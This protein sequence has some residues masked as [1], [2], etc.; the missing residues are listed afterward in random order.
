MSGGEKVISIEPLTRVEGEGHLRLVMENGKIKEVSL[1]ID[2]TPRL[3]EAFLVGRK[4]DEVHEIASRICGICYVAHQITA[5]RAVEK[6]IGVSVTEEIKKLR[7][8]L[9]FAGWIQSHSLHLAFLALPDY[10]GH[11]SVFSMLKSPEHKDLVTLGIKLR[12]L[13]N[14]LVEQLGGRWAHPVTCV[15][16][17][18][19]KLPDQKWV[20]KAKE[21][22]KEGKPDAEKLGKVVAKL[23][24]PDFT[25]DR[26]HV[27]LWDPKEYP[28]NEGRLR[29]NKGLDISEDEFTKFILES[30]DPKTNVKR[31][32]VKGRD[33]L[34]V[35]PLARVNL[36]YDKLSDDAKALADEA[37]V[38]F[39]SQNPFLQNLARAMELVHSFDEC[40]KILD[41]LDITAIKPKVEFEVKPGI[42]AAV[43]EAPR[44]IL[45]HGY[46]IGR[47]GL[48][49][50][51]NV[52]TPTVHNVSSAEADL[53]SFGPHIANLSVDEATLKCGMLIRAYDFCL[54]CSVHVLRL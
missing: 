17:G 31:S 39:P 50:S 22:L 52:V 16:G 38:K 45:Y 49:M 34:L 42:G 18:F 46:R 32:K 51:A 11:E 13:G 44:G 30:T 3:F 53:W 33:V 6:A 27:A 47:N 7:R 29:S 36:N 41:E 21:M 1:I 40:L 10:F 12:T 9:A 8:F 14:K 5:L 48:V 37:G 23:E 2:E 54:S 43:T 25:V 20:E 24:V 4:Y 26:E 15:V 35:G 19:S 28:I